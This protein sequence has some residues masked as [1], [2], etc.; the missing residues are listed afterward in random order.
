MVV[1]LAGLYAV[2]IEFVLPQIAKSE[3]VDAVESSCASCKFEIGSVA[4]GLLNPGQVRIRDVRVKEGY[5][6]SSE[7][8]VKIESIYLDINLAASSRDH[9]AIRE[10]QLREPDV[11]LVDG[12]A[13]S[14]EA[15]HGDDS[16]GPTFAIDST[17]LSDGVF[18]YTRNT[19]G[20]SATL[21]LAKIQ[22]EFTALGTSKDLKDKFV[23]AH[24]KT[25]IE[26][27]GETEVDL[28]VPMTGAANNVDVSVYIRDQ[29]LGVTTPFFNPNAGVELKGQIVKAR[30]RVRVRS[31]DLVA[32]AWII[33]HGLELKLNPMYDRS[34]AEAF[35]LN[36]GADL[37]MKETDLDLDKKDQTEYLHA[38]REPNE[39][40]VGFILRGLKEVAIQVARKAPETPAEKPRRHRAP[41]SR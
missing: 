16:T 8:L 40:I 9:I 36:I 34:K 12:D 25:Q 11:L 20:T 6:G 19:K 26:K 37:V 4:F 10:I 24:L 18:T 30:G 39:R 5:E 15:K 2:A 3:I 22:G 32:S 38:K 28:R 27:S 13:K 17:K 35:L 33:Y 1:L 14:P 29:D 31:N 41:V 23:E 7:L 21:H